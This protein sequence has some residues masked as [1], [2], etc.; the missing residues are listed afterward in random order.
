MTSPDNHEWEI[1]GNHHRL[2]HSAPPQ[3]EDIGDFNFSRI[4]FSKI[5]PVVRGK[6]KSIVSIT[7][8]LLKMKIMHELVLGRACS[9]PGIPL[10]S[11]LSR[12]LELKV[13]YSIEWSRGCNVYSF[14]FYLIQN[15]SIR[16]CV[17]PNLC[18]QESPDGGWR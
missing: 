4:C 14:K 15:L 2:C 17:L 1:M 5:L 18:R 6:N 3:T 12:V 13:F 7:L 11:V 16:L 10:Y 8:S 9:I